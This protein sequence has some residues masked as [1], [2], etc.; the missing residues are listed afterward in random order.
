VSVNGWDVS[1]K[2]GLQFEATES[3]IS[4]ELNGD[5][6]GASILQS[7][8][9]ERKEALVHTIPLNSR[10][11]QAVAESFFKLNARRFLVGRGVA[12]TEAGLRVGARVD[13]QN[14]GPLFSG[15]YYLT[16]VTH[17]FDGKKGLRT[18]FRAE[19]PGLGHN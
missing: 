5:S 2:S 8:I 17:V 16:E 14:L 1:S 11:A 12:Q 18:E 7:A 15:K 13:L 10:E 9:G 6:S 3:A 19:R 4:N